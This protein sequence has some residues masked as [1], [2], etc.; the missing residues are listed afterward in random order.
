MSGT[1]GRLFDEFAKLMNDA[2]GIAQSA[3]REMSTAFRSQAERFASELDLVRREEL[4]V[5]QDLAAKALAEVERLT[6]RVAALESRLGATAG[7]ENTEK[8]P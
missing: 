6:A 8:S 1:Q 2:A 4:E 5:V 7:E 3:G